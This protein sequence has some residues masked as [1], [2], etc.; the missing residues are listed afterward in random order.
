LPALTKAL[1]LIND[2]KNSMPRIEVME[3]AQPAFRL[4]NR[5]SAAQTVVATRIC[6]PSAV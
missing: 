6:L 2:Q 4:I 5:S 1:K 3:M